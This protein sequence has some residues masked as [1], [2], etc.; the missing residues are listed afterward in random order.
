MVQASV[1]TQTVYALSN[2]NVRRC[3]ATTCSI[4]G[5]LSVG[6]EVQTRSNISGERV[7]GSNDIWH[8]IQFRGEV[9]YIYSQNVSSQR[10][11]A[12]PNPA[13][14]PTQAPV[15][16]SSPADTAPASTASVPPTSFPTEAPLISTVP[17]QPSPLPA[18]GSPYT[19]NGIDDLNC[20][21][22]SSRAQ[23]QAHY[24]MCGNEDRLDGND[25]DGLACES[26]P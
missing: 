20:S 16:Q 8:E 2:L 26:L 7:S 5:S 19:C 24:N 6:D 25:N 12:N 17:P 18:G 23:A 10:P 15:Q 1:Q 3:A 21:D 13:S 9:G 22:F 11:A 14:A 4:L